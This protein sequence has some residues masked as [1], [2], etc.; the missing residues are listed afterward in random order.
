M[1]VVAMVYLSG[2]HSC[3]ARQGIIQLGRTHRM[4]LVCGIFRMSTSLCFI[5]CCL[6]CCMNFIRRTLCPYMT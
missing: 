4:S 5:L 2:L 3:R 1:G 6:V